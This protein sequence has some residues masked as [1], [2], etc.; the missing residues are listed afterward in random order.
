[1]ARTA[2]YLLILAGVGVASTL[3]PFGSDADSALRIPDVFSRWVGDDVPVV[4][5][6][7]VEA[8]AVRVAGPAPARPQAVAA[9]PPVS[10]THVV[11]TLPPRSE[12]SA[13]VP[14]AA[15]GPGTDPAALARDLQRELKRVGCYS[16][17]LNGVWSMTSRRAMKAFTDRVNA[18]LP[19]DTPDAILLSLVRAHQGDAC[20][21]PCPAHEA[22]AEDGRCLP[23]AVLA[24][25]NRKA[26]SPGE[27]A[28]RKEPAGRPAGVISGWTTTV[29]VL[30]PPPPAAVPPQGRMALAGPQTEPPPAA[31]GEAAPGSS[32]AARTGKAKVPRAARVRR[33][34]RRVAQRP[35]QRSRFVETFF[36]NLV[37]N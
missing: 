18:A 11:V 15:V 26:A 5:I 7:P 17:D 4:T 29:S 12:H 25:L 9:P 36:R 27:Q 35:A 1:M 2:G 23:T 34:D 14:H 24:H 20:G 10:P 33:E 22:L 6:V 37:L 32:P 8:P 31:A 19:V 3:L 28:K 16:G 30:P 13:M 21:K